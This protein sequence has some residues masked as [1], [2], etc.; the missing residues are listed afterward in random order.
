M[1]S[2]KIE[3]KSSS[4]KD[5]KHID[6]QYIHRILN[7]IENL[8]TNPFPIQCKKLHDSESSYRI[9]IGDYRVIYQVDSKTKTITIYYVRHRKDAY[10][11]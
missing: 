11:K 8:S 7:V 6:K 3:W 10:K 1:D 4:E 9:R 2:F 5:F